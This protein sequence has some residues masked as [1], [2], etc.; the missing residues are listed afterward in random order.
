[1]GRGESVR[2][3]RDIGEGTRMNEA[4]EFLQFV[5]MKETVSYVQRGRRY[6][7]LQDAELSDLWVSAFRAFVAGARTKR[8][9]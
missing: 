9:S 3:R 6:L 2:H 4:E 5:L 8:R 7:D 1:V